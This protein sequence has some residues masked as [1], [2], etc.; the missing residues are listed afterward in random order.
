M[1]RLEGR[2]ALALERRPALC[3][4]AV[5]LALAG[6]LASCAHSARPAVATVVPSPT[7]E[8]AFALNA[9]LARSLNLDNVLE[10]PC[11]GQSG[12]AS[13]EGDLRA[14][15]EAGFTGVR[16]PVRWSW[17]AAK[18]APYA[19]DPGFFTRVDQVV[20]AALAQGLAVVLDMHE[21]EEMA[22]G[23][24]AQRERFLALWM[25]IAGHYQSYPPELALELL[26]EP[27]GELTPGRWNDLLR[28]AI[29]G[30]RRTDPQRV[31]VAGPANWYGIAS[32]GDLELPAEDRAIIVTVHYYDPFEFTH[33]GAEWVE[34]AGD[35]L[36]T[37]WRGTPAE[38]EA[39]SR[40][41]DTAAGWGRANGRPMFLGEFGAY[42]RA[43][44][45]SRARYTAAVARGAEARGMSWAY[46]E[47]CAGFGVYDSVLRGWDGPLLR[48][49]VPPAPTP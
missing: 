28:E 25:Q 42:G 27:S 34:G 32:L 13:L 41:L 45:G 38:I 24:E 37:T 1:A 31:L 8:P 22:E 36:G 49:L 3:L 29:A 7:V 18:A 33:Q 19:V 16:I 17:H 2:V 35:W 23:P 40:D 43:D 6:S 15:A 48:A 11:D 26:N 9:H 12:A 30:I 21:Y 20:K 5:V 39:L 44:A 10:A 46:W 47:F 14:I 4:F